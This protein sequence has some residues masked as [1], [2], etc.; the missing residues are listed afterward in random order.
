M[1]KI[2][3]T[4]IFQ[5]N[6]TITV[7]VFIKKRKWAIEEIKF[8]TTEYVKDTIC[9]EYEIES[10]IAEPR[11]R[12]GNSNTRGIKTIGTWNFS[13]KEKQVEKKKPSKQTAK[14]KQE[15]SKKPKTSIRNRMSN[16]ANKT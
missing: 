4:S 7:T 2:I 8:L 14:P 15:S 10:I 9:K 1:L 16:I 6:N 13:I 12:V 3:D 5:K 11:H